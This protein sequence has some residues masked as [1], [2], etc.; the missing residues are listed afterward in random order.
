MCNGVPGATAAAK[1]KCAARINEDTAGLME[2]LGEAVEEDAYEN[3][4]GQQGFQEAKEKA[5]RAVLA[6]SLAAE[7]ACVPT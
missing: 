3:W 7:L 2:E 4:G 6:A 1:A 5:K